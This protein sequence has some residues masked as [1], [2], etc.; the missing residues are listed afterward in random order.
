MI[1]LELYTDARVL[2]TELLERTISDE[3]RYIEGGEEDLEF[4]KRLL[5]GTRQA[6]V[7]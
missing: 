7:C 6:P 4:P 3:V 1:S 2:A 5:F